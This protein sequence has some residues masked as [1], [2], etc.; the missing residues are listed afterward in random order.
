[1]D[2]RMAYRKII[3]VGASLGAFEALP[4]RVRWLACGSVDRARSSMLPS[5]I[6]CRYR[7]L[8]KDQG[9]RQKADVLRAVER[10]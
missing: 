2:P 10:N 9:C 8:A 1:M 6:A 3:V 4:R 7:T 5:A